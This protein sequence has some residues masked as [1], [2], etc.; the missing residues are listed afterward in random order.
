MQS[1]TIFQT[2]RLILASLLAFLIAGATSLHAG[3][4]VGQKRARKSHLRTA[5]SCLPSSASAELNIN[6]VRC[7]LHN[8]GDM[9]WDLAG[10][11]RYEIPRVDDPALAKH[12]SFAASLWIGGLDAE[13]NLRVAA[14]TYRQSGNDYFPGPLTQNGAVTD[15][16]CEDWDKMWKINK[17]EID[18]FRA[19]WNTFESTGASFSIDD[20]PNVKNWPAFGYNAEERIA[21]APFVDVDGDIFNYSPENGDY[22]DIRPMEGGGEPD[23]AIWWVINDKGD[24]HTE[25]GGLPIGLEIQMMAFA[26]TTSNAINDM[27]FYRYRVINKSG[28]ALQNTYMGQWIDV[29]IG[30]PSDDYVG[31]DTLRGLGFGYNGLPVDNPS[32]GGYGA[33]PPSFGVD[34]FQGPVSDKGERLKMTKFI[35]YDND[36]SLRGNPEVAVHYYGYLRG[37]W[38]DG[39]PLTFGGNGQGG[40]TPTDYMFPGDPAGCNATGGWSE[41]SEGIKPGDRRFLQSAGPFTLYNGA[42]NDIITGAVWARSD[43][44][45]Q[46]GS[47]C[48]MIKADDLAQALF[49]SRFQLLDGPD[50]P[51][52]AIEEFDQELVISW[53]YDDPNLFNNFAEGYAQSD[54]VLA[55]QQI[56]DSVFEFQ[57]YL[58]FQLKDATVSA[59]EL[60]NTERARILAQC[61][62]KD[63]I[64]TIVN[65]TEQFVAGLDDPV[66]VD[67]V[68]VQG[69]DKGIFHSVHATEDLFSDTDDRRL[70]NYTTY[71]YAVIAYAY[72]GVPSDGIQFVQ[73]NRY[74][75]NTAAV[76]HKIDFEQ[77]GTVVNAEYGDGI[78]TVQTAG[79][80]NGGRFVALNAETVQQILDHGAVSEIGYQANAGPVALKVV[81]PKELHA[82]DYRL[83]IVGD[84]AVGGVD[85]VALTA[86]GP[87]TER[88][89]AEWILYA[90]GEEVFSSTYIERNDP[91]T[92]LSYRPMPL[93]GVER[94]I[95][96]H[97]FAVAVED[98]QH[99]G[100]VAEDY[101]PVI[102][103]TQTYADP[104]QNWLSGLR[105]HDDF[106][107]VN[108]IKAG[109]DD[110]DRGEGNA[111][112]SNAFIYDPGS[113]YENLLSGTW[114]PFCMARE[115]NAFDKDGKISP[116]VQIGVGAP[117]STVLAAEAVSLDELPDIDIVFTADRSQWSRCV[118]IETTMEQIFGSGAYP[119]TARWAQGLDENLEPMPGQLSEATQ[120]WSMFPGYAIDV[121]TG[122]RLNVFFGENSWDKQNNGNDLLFNPTSDPGS[123]GSEAG[124]RHFV[125]VSRTA[126]DGCAAIHTQLANGTRT[127]SGSTL[128]FDPN[129][130]STDMRQVYKDIAWVGVPM[131]GSNFDFTHPDQIPSDVRISLRINQPFRSRA[132][133]S[134]HPVV[135]FNTEDIAAQLGVRDVAEKSLMEC[136]RVVPNPYYAFSKYEKSQFQSIVKVT[137]LPQQCRLRIFTL[138][139]TLV[140]EY[141]KD[142]EA[143]DQEWDMKNAAGVPVASGVYLIHVDA[144]D[145]G[146]TVVKLMAVM[147]R[148]DL[149]AY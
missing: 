123:T 31:C 99:A 147:P 26:F 115:F 132:G 44:N 23:Q 142:S 89:R 97:G 24:I 126:Y 64:S 143:P 105:D 33:H 117:V 66:I 72:N 76:P 79:V 77:F 104:M 38:K 11:P 127:G 139:G 30:S 118:V 50:A 102:G 40:S 51:Q 53:G 88:R 137:N 91:K 125:Y 14:A 131:L 41:L 32:D 146:E 57:G 21:M 62:L 116:G 92:G 140:R 58:V 108:W 15:A 124:G 111:V 29:D 46:L 5:S 95:K 12:S 74:F 54:P 65:R 98:P 80:G 9:W 68:M 36:W 47:I 114:S 49:D 122:Q 130:P 28:S 19:A 84:R 35:A 149:G 61:D 138:N 16:V 133:S 42:V 135:T 18:A 2:P 93:S 103:V 3:E 121:N 48:E 34:F 90:N 60:F 141:R 145:L 10:L 94:V 100:V 75:V 129:D 43:Q 78:P 128:W 67:Q 81:N 109:D 112:L 136:I 6:N 8:G 110:D 56:P 4:N 134:D 83:E 107:V 17:T 59:N 120:G 70:K 20:F 55:A 69:A 22:P 148:V 37:F 71:Y 63:G 7:L 82:A 45:D 13:Q 101:D 27:T 39:S 106:E 73:G 113:H 85:T 1:K 52:V 87:I 86:N 119:M 25:T 144:G 96:G